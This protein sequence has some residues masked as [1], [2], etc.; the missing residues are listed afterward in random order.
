MI[1]NRTQVGFCRMDITPHM[2]VRLSGYYTARVADGIWDP[3]YVNAIAFCDGVNQC[4][5]LVCDLVGVFGPAAY[6]WSVEIAQKIGIPPEA[7]FF[8]HTHTHTGPVVTTNREPSD[9]IYDTWLQRRLC[10]A[11]TLALADCKP[12]T[13]ILGTEGMTYD[14]THVRRFLMKDGTYKTNPEYC[15]PNIVR[16]ACEADESFRLVRILR[17]DGPEIALVN[18]QCHPDMIGGTKI[19]ADYPGYF[20]NKIEAERPGIKSIFINGAEGQLV[21][22]DR[23]YPR[24]YFPGTPASAKQFGEALAD[25]VLPAFNKAAPIADGSLRF[26]QNT[27]VAATKWDPSR[28][29]E[30]NRI[31]QLHDAGRDHEIEPAWLS[32]EL[33]AE[34]YKLKRLE[35]QQL[36]HVSMVASAI[37]VGD[38]AFIGFPGEP[39]CEIGK[40]LRDESPYPMTFIC[41]QTNGHNSYFPTAESYDQDGYEPRNNQFVKGTGEGFAAKCLELLQR[42]KEE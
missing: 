19:S 14:L 33:V 18:F 7:L 38:L 30:V 36:T 6:T 9:P 32:S 10:D 22:A 12:V 27:Y 29:E 16:P 11:A 21:P 5:I 37:I 1:D 26:G 4:V 8:T 40:A 24:K 41:C 15:D 17:E 23:R 28:V 2:G 34:A 3:L 13:Q 31:L 20:R 35:A 25:F 42:L 39:F